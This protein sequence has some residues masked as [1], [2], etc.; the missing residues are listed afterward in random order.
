MK[1]ILR[2]GLKGFLKSVQRLETRF[3]RSY[4]NP[5]VPMSKLVNHS[6]WGGYLTG[7]GNKE[8]MRILE[9]GSREVTGHSSA[10]QQFDQAEYVGFDYYAGPNVDVVGDA[11]QLSSYFEG[12]QFD[13]IYS[14]ACF[15]HFCYALA[16][17]YGNS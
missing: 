16:G 12:Q 11:H 3:D 14:S 6:K 17:C 4:L 10:R 1:A 2:K 15:E 8:G 9:V 7:I 5:E 13:L